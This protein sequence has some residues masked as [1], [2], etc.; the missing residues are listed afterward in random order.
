MAS[1]VARYRA[2]ASAPKG[3]SDHPGSLVAGWLAT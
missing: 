3:V 2:A 1:I